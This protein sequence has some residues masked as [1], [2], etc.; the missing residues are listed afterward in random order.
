MAIPSREADTVIMSTQVPRLYAARIPK[1][2]AITKDISCAKTA[3]L[4]VGAK[5]SPMAS[6]TVV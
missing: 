2:T 5:Y 1:G 3:R 4:K 6:S